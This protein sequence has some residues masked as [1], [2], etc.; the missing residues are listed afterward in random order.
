M[1]YHEMLARGLKV[2]A[3]TMAAVMS[4]AVVAGQPEMALG[5]WEGLTS[6]GVR[7]SPACANARLEA[8]L[9]LV[10]WFHA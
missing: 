10:R 7:P 3:A 4:T 1:L 9:Q 8:L 5:M 6:S 2:N